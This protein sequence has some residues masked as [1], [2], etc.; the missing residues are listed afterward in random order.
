MTSAMEL[1]LFGRVKLFETSKS[2]L[3]DLWNRA[4]GKNE[5]TIKDKT[6]VDAISSENGFFKVETITGEKFTSQNILL[7][8]GRRGSPRKLN[9]PGEETEKVAYRLLE[10]EQISG[11]DVLVVGG[12][13]SALEEAGF[14]TKFA[15]K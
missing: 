10:P 11:K 12:G 3:L 1:P 14:L 5:I 15:S 8:I 9:I 2:E 13:D 6:K 4:L 7:A